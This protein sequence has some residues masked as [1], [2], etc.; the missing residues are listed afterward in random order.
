MVVSGHPAEYSSRTST[1]SSMYGPSFNTPQ[2]PRPRFASDWS[3]GQIVAVGRRGQLGSSVVHDRDH[4][5]L[6]AAYRR[7]TGRRVCST[8]GSSMVEG[9]CP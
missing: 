9:G 2:S 6:V 1:P 8:S 4:H 7:S 5:Q 3:Y